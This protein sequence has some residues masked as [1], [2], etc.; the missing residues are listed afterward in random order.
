MEKYESD[1]IKVYAYELMKKGNDISGDAYVVTLT[2]EGILIAIADGLG[3]GPEAAKSS[4]SIRHILREYKEESVYDLMHRCNNAMKGKRGAAVTLVKMSWKTKEVET[5]GVGNVRLYV[6]NP[7]GTMI[8]PLPEQ[9]YL[10]GKPFR[11]RV[12]RYTY[13]SGAMFFIHSDGIIMK[14]PKKHLEQSYSAA[15]LAMQLCDRV[16][17]NDD[18][19]FVAAEML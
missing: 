14:S 13:E 8:Y 6:R 10:S 4:H 3:N 19:T 15:R 5:S 9:G 1:A 18:A 7:D 2:S 11:P 16:D 17:R 12:E